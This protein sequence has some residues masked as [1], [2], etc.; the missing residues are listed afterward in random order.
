M[1]GNRSTQPPDPATRSEPSRVVDPPRRG[2]RLGLDVGAV[3]I[4]VARSDP[5]GV[6]ATPVSTITVSGDPTGDALEAIAGIVAEHAAYVVYVGLP[7]SLD[8]SDGP[9]ARRIRDY[10]RR[11]AGRIAPTRVRLVDERL[12]TVTAHRQ[13]HESGRQERDH[14]A[15]VDQ[16]A[17]V[18]ILQAALDAERATG[19]EVGQPSGDRL[20]K[21]RRR[22]RKDRD[23]RT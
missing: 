16:A 19:R 7:L 8:G 22:G 2:V 9:A 6:L 3:R 13:L 1:P 10:A 5:D 11:L 4:G 14:R 21:P 12:T 18:L 20:G 17:A 15:V 23:E